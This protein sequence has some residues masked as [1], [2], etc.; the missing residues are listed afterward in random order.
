MLFQ[1][2][3]NIS[4]VEEFIKTISKDSE[5]LLSIENILETTE[6]SIKL[7]DEMLSNLTVSIF[8]FVNTLSRLKTIQILYRFKN[9]LSRRMP[10]KIIDHRFNFKKKYAFHRKKFFGYKEE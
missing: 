5:P 3:G 7:S 1:D 10:K 4:C 8:I 2:K 6:I 9:K